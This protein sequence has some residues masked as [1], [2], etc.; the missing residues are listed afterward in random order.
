[1]PDTLTSI[2]SI[3]DEFCPQK[4]LN[5]AAGRISPLLYGFLI[6]WILQNKK[7][8]IKPGKHRIHT[9]TF[10]VVLQIYSLGVSILL[11]ILA[12]CYP[13]L[14]FILHEPP[15]NTTMHI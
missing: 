4:G 14:Y 15:F 7:G 6:K 10:I 13:I 5:A 1:M 8:E 2:F 11:L 9:A 12:N 3:K